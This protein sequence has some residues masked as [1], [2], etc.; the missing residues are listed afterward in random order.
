MERAR[1][2]TNSRLPMAQIVFGTF[3]QSTTLVLF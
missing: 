3:R 1:W 2:F